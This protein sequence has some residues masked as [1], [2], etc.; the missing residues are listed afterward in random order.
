LED[1]FGYDHEILGL[2]GAVLVIFP[3]FFAALIAYAI[4]MFNFQKR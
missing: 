3:V 4:T 1:Y 2:V